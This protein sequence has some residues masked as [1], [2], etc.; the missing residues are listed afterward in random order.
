MD[1]EKDG[2]RIVQQIPEWVK[3]SFFDREKREKSIH[4][5]TKTL[6]RELTPL[7]E[8]LWDELSQKEDE[9]LEEVKTLIRQDHPKEAIQ[10][11]LSESKDPERLKLMELVW[12]DAVKQ[13]EEERFYIFPEIGD[14]VTD[15][16]VIEQLR[17]SIIQDEKILMSA[18]GSWKSQYLFLTS[19]RVFIFKKGI[20]A[21]LSHHG[22]FHLNF[23]AIPYDSITKVLKDGN[24]LAGKLEIEHLSQKTV[25]QFNKDF[26]VQMD[27]V[28]LKIQELQPPP[29]PLP[30]RN[31]STTPITTEEEPPVT[32]EQTTEAEPPATTGQMTEEMP[33]QDPAKPAPTE[34]K[35]PQT[36]P[37]VIADDEEN[38]FCPSCGVKVLPDDQ[39]CN[40]CGSS[41]KKDEDGRLQQSVD[42]FI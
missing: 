13:I 20:S 17:S 27:E 12:E 29:K 24:W 1:L 41:L 28:V 19:H 21:F 22:S 40:E 8:N 34:E 7:A 3:T 15:T 35:P 6:A 37:A 23:D 5:I 33:Q 4:Q 32:T 9:V 16:E 11:K 2:L 36:G 39:F 38:V 31:D 25:F 10:E 18:T 26:N 30:H 42:P 14:R